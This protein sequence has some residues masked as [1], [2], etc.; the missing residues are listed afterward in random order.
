MG[1]TP[2]LFRLTINISLAILRTCTHSLLWWVVSTLRHLQARH[3]WCKTV[4]LRINRSCQWRQTWYRILMFQLRPRATSNSSISQHWHSHRINPCLVKW[5]QVSLATLI[6]LLLAWMAPTA[7]NKCSQMHRLCKRTLG[8]LCRTSLL[9]QDWP[10]IISS[11]RISFLLCSLTS[12][13]SRSSTSLLSMVSPLLPISSICP[14]MH[15]SRSAMQIPRTCPSKPIIYSIVPLV[16]KR[17]LSTNLVRI[18]QRILLKMPLCWCLSS[19]GD[20]SLLRFLSRYHRPAFLIW[21]Q[22]DCLLPPPCQLTSTIK[23]KARAGSTNRLKLVASTRARISLTKIAP[24]VSNSSRPLRTWLRSKSISKLLLAFNWV[25]RLLLIILK[26]VSIWIGLVSRMILLLQLAVFWLQTSRVIRVELYSSSSL[27]GCLCRLSLQ[28]LP[29]RHLIK[30]RWTLSIR[31]GPCFWRD[32]AQTQQPTNLKFCL[33][34]KMQVTRC[35]SRVCRRTPR[36]E[37]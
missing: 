30:T 12:I 27:N 6:F 29:K 37:K 32:K 34:Q 35:M 2:K 33:F 8:N 21:I 31:L 10:P 11:N 17:C 28:R 36:K 18:R 1:V 16:I 26:T 3:S 23:W 22:W 13:L 24:S 20:L 5:V 19:T 7:T 9:R 4:S 25:S 14:T 15:L